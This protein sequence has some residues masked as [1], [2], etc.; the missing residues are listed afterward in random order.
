MNLYVWTCLIM[1]LANTAKKYTA[2]FYQRL[3]GD[4]NRGRRGWRRGNQEDMP[5]E[6]FQYLCQRTKKEEKKKEKKAR[7]GQMLLSE[8]R[9]GAD[10]GESKGTLRLWRVPKQ[11]WEFVTTPIITTNLSPA[12]FCCFTARKIQMHHN[13]TK[14]NGNVVSSGAPGCIQGDSAHIPPF[15]FKLQSKSY[16]GSATFAC[17]MHGSGSERKRMCQTQ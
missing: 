5:T 4:V 17:K 2:Y 1:T 15:F 8:R 3:R 9:E 7:S 10:W 13:H 6:S 14:S 11:R 12:Y 16:A